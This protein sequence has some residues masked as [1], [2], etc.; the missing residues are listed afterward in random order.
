[1]AAAS[2]ARASAMSGHAASSSSGTPS[3]VT[4]EILKNGSLSFFAR[5]SSAVDALGIVNRIDL[6][7]GDQLRLLEQSRIVEIELAA[8]RVEILDRIA[9]R[10]ARHVD[11]VDQHLRPLDVPQELVAEPVALVRAFDQPGHVGDDEA[12]I[13]AQRDHA[14]VRRQRGERIVGDLRLRRRDHAR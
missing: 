2:A 4:A 6:V 7:G 12:A 13:V 10:R 1:M 3:P 9:A 11:Q 5:F 14:E 8:D